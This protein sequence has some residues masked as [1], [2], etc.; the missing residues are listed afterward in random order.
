MS[1]LF[2]CM[3]ADRLGLLPPKELEVGERENFFLCFDA[4]KKEGG[5]IP[6]HTHQICTISGWG[7]VEGCVN[8]WMHSTP[9]WHI[10]NF[11]FFLGGWVGR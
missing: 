8:G 1:P 11:Y 3:D 10:H 2:E 6:T 4:E 5:G 7:G 9:L